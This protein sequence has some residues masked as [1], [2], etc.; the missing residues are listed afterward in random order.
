MFSPFAPLVRPSN[1]QAKTPVF[2]N[3]TLNN[4]NDLTSTVGK[5]GHRW[6]NRW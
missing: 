6:Q 1:F 3:P 2:E 5:F 4:F